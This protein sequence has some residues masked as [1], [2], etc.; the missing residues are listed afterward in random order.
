MTSVK[1]CVD[2]LIKMARLAEQTSDQLDELHGIDK[3]LGIDFSDEKTRA[4]LNEINVPEEIMREFLEILDDETLHRIHA[5]M[6]SGRD[7][8][9]PQILKKQFSK[10]SKKEVIRTIC[11][12]RPALEVYLEKGIDTVNKHGLDIETF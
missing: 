2:L 7:N 1:K 4:R 9:S 11:E 5:I 3:E 6:Y 8:M 10:D 12:K